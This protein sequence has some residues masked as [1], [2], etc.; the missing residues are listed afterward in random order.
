MSASSVNDQICVIR[1][2]IVS[3][4]K[5]FDSF[6]DFITRFPKTINVICLSES[7]FNIRNLSY[8]NLPG[9]TLFY[10]NAATK[11]GGSA[12]YVSN[13]IKCTQLS[14]I[15]LKFD[16]CENVWVELQLNYNETLIVGTVY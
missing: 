15:K 6:I 13:N 7:R 4:Q 10:N 1:L 3:L 12:I 14:Q 16:G 9:H 11:D 2:N 8:C 5:K